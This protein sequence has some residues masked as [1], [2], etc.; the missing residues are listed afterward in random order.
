MLAL[1]GEVVRS[2]ELGGVVAQAAVKKSIAKIADRA[3]G[4]ANPMA[5]GEKLAFG[6]G[7]IHVLASFILSTVFFDAT[8][9]AADIAPV[10]RV[11]E[12]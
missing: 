8:N 5:G 9:D 10:Y 11:L 7:I 12:I 4:I 1:S 2:V 3:G 6:R